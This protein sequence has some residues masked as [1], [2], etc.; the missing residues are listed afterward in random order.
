MTSEKNNKSMFLYTALI[1]LVAILLI[2]ISFFGQTN[3]K[4]NQPSSSEIQQETKNTEGIGDGI[5]QRASVLSK[6]NVEL[7]NEN[8]ELNDLLTASEERAN[9][10]QE[11]NEVLKIYISNYELLINVYQYIQQDNADDANEILSIINY[12][13]LTEEQKIIYDKLK[14]ILK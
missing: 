8:K 7:V 12:D 2:I 10:F 3:V 4:N 9:S 11:E 14:N 1:F 6:Y 13:R 5:T